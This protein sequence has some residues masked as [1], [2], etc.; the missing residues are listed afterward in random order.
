MIFLSFEKCVHKLNM[1]EM[2]VF[3]QINCVQGPPTAVY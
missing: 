1:N 2:I 3:A